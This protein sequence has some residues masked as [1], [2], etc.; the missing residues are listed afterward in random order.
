[1]AEGVRAQ[2]F[3]VGLGI[4]DLMEAAKLG[5]GVGAEDNAALRHDQATA[6]QNQSSAAG[7]RFLA[8]WTAFSASFSI[9]A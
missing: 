3:G 7:R 1:M 5:A 6:G 2:G 8:S 4:A 9:W